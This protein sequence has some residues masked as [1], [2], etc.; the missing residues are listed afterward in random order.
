MANRRV[1]Q[2][3][4]AMGIE[5]WVPRQ[6]TSSASQ[7]EVAEPALAI[8]LPSQPQIDWE[9]LQQ[10]VVTCTAC[11]LHQTRTQT[12]FGIGNRQAEWMWIGEAPGED[13]DRQGEPF[14]GRAGQLLNMMLEAIG[15]E[16]KNIY[17]ANVLKC[18][19]PDNRSPKSNEMACCSPFLHHQIALLQPKLIVALGAVAAQHLLTTTTQIGQLRGKCWEFAKTP[20][21]ATYHPAYLLRR[22]LEKRK[23][24]QDLQFMCQIFAEI[25]SRPPLS[26]PLR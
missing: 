21:I 20:L 25:S 5:V 16:R 14:V 2:Y 26:S 17:I 6:A 4:N 9:T 1:L 19:P 22:P 12:V 3:L 18:R 7:E 13:E 23:S 10:Q 24:W 8:P 11:E 15:L